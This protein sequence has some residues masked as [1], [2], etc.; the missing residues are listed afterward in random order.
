VTKKDQRRPGDSIYYETRGEGTETVVLING[1]ARSSRHWLDFPDVL[2][3]KGYRVVLTDNRGFG[4]SRDLPLRYMSHVRDFA[5]DIDKILRKEKIT[6][7]HIIGLSLGGM[8]ANEL[9]AIENRRVRSLT[10]VNS[11][12]ANTVLLRLSTVGLLRL[13][14]MGAAARNIRKRSTI[15][16]KALLNYRED[17][18][19]FE[20]LLERLIEIEKLEPVKIQN[21]NSQINAARRF[22]LKRISKNIECP[23]QI[24]YSDADKFV[25]NKNSFSLHKLLPHSELKCIKGHGH[26]LMMSAPQE[27]AKVF[28]ELAS[29]V[30]IKAK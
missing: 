6:E 28:E 26:E 10:I 12:S 30:A 13:G 27:V 4:R 29:Q 7:F 16:V 3:E 18:P 1:L 25:P 22:N 8:I 2:V 15:E 17:N 19:K 24:V 14:Q 5:V 21:V 11:S 20:P 23:T 9:A